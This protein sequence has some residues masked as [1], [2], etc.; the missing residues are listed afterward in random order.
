L[1]FTAPDCQDN[2]KHASSDVEVAEN[3]VLKALNSALFRVILLMVCSF[4]AL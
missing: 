3:F 4:Q 2:N 1:S